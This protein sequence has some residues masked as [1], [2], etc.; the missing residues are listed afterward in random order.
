[1]YQ[2]TIQYQ[3]IMA[4]AVLTATIYPNERADDIDAA[5]DKILMAEAR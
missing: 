1:M 4:T 2:F 5:F 3:N